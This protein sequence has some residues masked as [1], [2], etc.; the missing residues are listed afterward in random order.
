[1]SIFPMNIERR[2]F[3]GTETNV[4]KQS[5]HVS[6]EKYILVWFYPGK[7]YAVTHLPEHNGAPLSQ[8]VG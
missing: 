8:S 3:F 2:L 1:M 4:R 7:R 5:L 6:D